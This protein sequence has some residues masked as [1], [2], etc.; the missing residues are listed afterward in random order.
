LPHKG[1]GEH[2][3]LYIITYA[4]APANAATHAADRLCRLAPFPGP[5]DVGAPGEGRPPVGN[6]GGG[7][8]VGN[9]CVVGRV[10]VGT[11]PGGTPVA[12]AVVV[13]TAVVVAPLLT[14]TAVQT[15]DPPFVTQDFEICR[16]AD[17]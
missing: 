14:T 11:I 15:C 8:F 1:T 3:I 2:C 5:L 16:P 13:Y 6:P 17:G 4:I 10:P 12:P 9:V 7:E